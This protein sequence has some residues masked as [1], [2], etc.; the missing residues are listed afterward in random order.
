[1]PDLF[2]QAQETS[3][4]QLADA[5]DEHQRSRRLTQ[6]MSRQECLDCD[7]PIPEARRQAAPGCQRC[8]DCQRIFE[9]GRK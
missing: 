9:G 7:D 5:L 1:M 3:E 8:I 4:R 2:D 6:Q